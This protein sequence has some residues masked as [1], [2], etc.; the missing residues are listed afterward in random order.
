MESMEAIAIVTVLALIQ[1][2]VFS[3]DVAKA[4]GKYK[5]S[6]PSI[7]GNPDFERAFRVHQ[8]TMEQ[9]VLFL[10]A[11]WMFGYYVHPLWGAGIGIVF[12]IGRFVYRAGYLQDP[13]KRGTGFT[14][15]IAASSILLLGG[16]I[17]AVMNLI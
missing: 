13:S 17:G 14:I 3:L 7:S 9:L 4:R 5:V 12:I 10:P 16:L 15:G 1:Y 11:L 6:A 2:F 8:N